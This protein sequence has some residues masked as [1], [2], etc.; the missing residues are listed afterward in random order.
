MHGASVLGAIGA[1]A[2]DL[3]CPA[4]VQVTGNRAAYNDHPDYLL[5]VRNSYGIL[6]SCDRPVVPVVVGDKLVRLF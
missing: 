2:V 6:V 4:I 1:E 3:Q 5:A